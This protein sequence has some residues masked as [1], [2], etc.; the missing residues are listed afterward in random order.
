ME[1]VMQKNS[2]S[3]NDSAVTK[4]PTGVK[5]GFFYWNLEISCTASI[6]RLKNFSFMPGLMAQGGGGV[7]P[8]NSEKVYIKS[9]VAQW[10]PHLN[11][12]KKNPHILFSR[13]QHQQHL[14]Q[15]GGNQQKAV[16]GDILNM[17]YQTMTINRNT[18]SNK[19][20]TIRNVSRNPYWNWPL[21]ISVHWEHFSSSRVAN[22]SRDTS[23]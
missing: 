17:W 21:R 12:Y 14:L 16:V 1:D 15:M 11:S 22:W 13:M 2:A 5:L 10:L 23:Y 18:Q 3:E 19:S 7:K 4:V 8:P 20:L 9:V 6:L